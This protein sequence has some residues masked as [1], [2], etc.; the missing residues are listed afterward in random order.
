[1]LINRVHMSASMRLIN[2]WL[3]PIRF[4]TCW[5][6]CG[7]YHSFLFSEEFLHVTSNAFVDFFEFHRWLGSFCRLTDWS[8]IKNVLSACDFDRL[9]NCV[10]AGMTDYWTV[11]RRFFLRKWI[12]LSE[13]LTVHWMFWVV[14]H[15]I[16]ILV[17]VKVCEMHICI[18]IAYFFPATHNIH[19]RMLMDICFVVDIFIVAVQHCCIE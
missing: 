15:F 19:R 8:L 2:L 9:Q 4:W 16:S 12:Y 3:I 10:R 11:C 6:S 5:G 17:H 1:M 18:G 14:G 13:V 7:R